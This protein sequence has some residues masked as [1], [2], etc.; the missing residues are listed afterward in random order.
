MEPLAALQRRQAGAHRDPA[1]ET[2]AVKRLQLL[3]SQAGALCLQCRGSLGRHRQRVSAGAARQ[4]AGRRACRVSAAIEAE[5]SAAAGS[6]PREFLEEL[7][8]HDSGLDRVIR[9]GYGLLGLVTY[10]TVRPEGDA[11]LDDHQG[12]QGAAGGRRDP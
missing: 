5:V 9:A 3:T 2:R 11:R 12:H 4:G 1:G 6:R 8:L 10:F 7:G